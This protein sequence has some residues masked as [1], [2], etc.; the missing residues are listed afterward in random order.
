[1]FLKELHDDSVLDKQ[2][3]NVALMKIEENGTTE[4]FRG[5]IIRN[6]EN[7]SDV[8]NSICLVK[9]QYEVKKDDFEKQ[10]II[11]HQRIEDIFDQLGC[12]NQSLKDKNMGI[13]TSHET[14]WN[15][16]ISNLAETVQQNKKVLQSDNF[17]YANGILETS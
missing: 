1:M 11:W 5:N 2:E 14:R 3:Y 10:R 12:L 7:V 16:L 13:L 9:T 17:D 15:I 4:Y 6:Y 8:E